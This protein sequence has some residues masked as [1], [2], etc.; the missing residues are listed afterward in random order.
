MFK[1]VLSASAVLAVVVSAHATPSHGG[2]QVEPQ[3]DE[4]FKAFDSRTSSGCAVAAYQ[5]DRIVLRRAYGMANLDHDV[6][7]TPASVFHVASVSKQFTA[8]AILLLAQDGKLSIDDDVRKYIPEL[9]DLGERITIRHLAHHTSGIR[10]QW[11]L[12]GLAGWR[13]SRDLITDDDVLSLLS[14]QKALNFRPG[15]RHLYS[16]SGYT[17]MA[18]IVSRV[19]G[20]SFRE[21]TTERIFQPLGMVNT[22]FRDNFREI[23]RNQAYGYT[24]EGDVVRLSVTNFDTAGATSLLTTVE[25]LVRWHAN[26]DDPKVGGRAMIA[27]LLE[28]GV[29]NDGRTIDYAFG[30][31]HGTY[32]GLPTVGH[33]GSDAGYRSA[34]LRFPGQRFG[35]AAL[36]NLASANP[37]ELSRRVA[38]VFLAGRL[39]PQAA[40]V[41]ADDAP[42]SPVPAADLGRFAG[43]YWNEVEAAARRFVVEDGRLHALLGNQRHAMKPLGEGR[44]V[45]SSEPRAQVAFEAGGPDGPPRVTITAPGGSGEVFVRAEPFSPTAA[46]LAEF[47]GAYRSEEIEVV[48]RIAL[49]EGALSLERLKSRPARLQPIVKDTFTS[50]PG[51]IR[52]LRNASGVV[53]GFDLE[54]GRVRQVRFWK[55]MANSQPPTPTSQGGRSGEATGA[56]GRGESGQAASQEVVDGLL[57]ADRAFSRAS[58]KMDVTA[59]LT[60]MFAEDVIV[61]VPGNRFARGLAEARAALQSNPEN[62]TSRIEWTP[63]RGG[64]SADGQHGFTFG[65]M[66]LHRQDGTAVPLKYV[67]YWIRQPSGWRVA[68]YRRTRRAEG[69]VSRELRPPALPAA[70]VPVSSDA[71]ATK[72]FREGLDAAERAFSDEAQ[73]IGLGPAF[74]KY[75]SADAVNT[76][77]PNQAEF[78]TGSEAIGRV[79]SEGSPPGGA[80]IS[81][82]PDQVIVA[83]SGD[84][85]VTIGMIRPN[86][87]AGD[88]KQPAGVPFFTIWRRASPA[89][90]WRYIAE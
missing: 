90:P 16:N 4:I 56:A 77:G 36:C 32:R 6:P 27:G 10:D 28:R 24:R 63:I 47:A 39:R 13:Y 51:T 57:A 29:L 12:L 86:A 7:L 53:T 71:S 81:W 54:A 83:S 70:I 82:A 79:V 61:P 49:D 42:E 48:Y 17:L 26:F 73:K 84:L 87:P 52:F 21:F 74:A 65:Y 38:D 20:K 1:R 69:A 75:G 35:V 25:D 2:R 9:P 50:Q 62:A 23:V 64:I 85:G 33:G 44:F 72:R 66:T 15:E 45:L 22:H 31:S 5:D 80:T 34:Y 3:I 78:V 40:E 55:D 30:I 43:L 88:P 68:V 46:Q 76:G 59:G 19:S 18:L 37:T 8:A 89:D 14:R 58:A 11:S 60:A 67:A 41:P